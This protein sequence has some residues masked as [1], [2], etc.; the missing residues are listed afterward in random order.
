[1]LRG[2]TETVPLTVF[3]T[4]AL[5]P[6]GSTATPFG[7]V[8]TGTRASN[9]IRS[10]RMSK[11]LTLLLSGFTTARKESSAGR[12]SGWEDVGPE[13]VSGP[14]AAAVTV[15]LTVKSSDPRLES[16]FTVLV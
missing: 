8:C 13:N 6:S 12:A 14:A 2:I 5:E 10:K 4:Y 15:R 3:A 11:K 16:I 1:M 9:R 7:S